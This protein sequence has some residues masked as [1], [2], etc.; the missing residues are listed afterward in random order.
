MCARAETTPAQNVSTGEADFTGVVASVDD[1]VLT[2][3]CEDIVAE[4]SDG[5]A[6]GPPK[7]HRLP[8]LALRTPLGSRVEVRG[9]PEPK[10]VRRAGGA[11]D[12]AEFGD[13]RVGDTVEVWL[14]PGNN[15]PRAA[16]A[17]VFT[18]GG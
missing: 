18:P 2:E 7:D 1:I 4:G 15:Q 9:A 13:I 11:Y 6:C 14:A 8:A 17:I 10:V 3:I 5:T 12:D 16:A